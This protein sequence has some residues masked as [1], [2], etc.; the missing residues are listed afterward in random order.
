MKALKEFPVIETERL[1]LSQLQEGDIPFVTE[2]LQDKIFSDLTSN[3][4]Y[5]YTREHA[6]FWMKMSRESF[7]NNTGY[8]FA[9]RNKEGN[10]L[11]AIG[12]HDREDDKAELGY[13]MGK[14][15]WN[16]GYITEAATALIGFG[17]QELQLN[18]IYATYFLQNPASGRIME[19][20]GMEQ[21]ALLKQ[22]VRKGEEYFDIMMYSVLKNKN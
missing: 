6:E 1:I 12:L 19:K 3:I 11:G 22:H 10:I 4:P 13:W 21:E 14:P 2:Y 20:V 7:E 18:K 8:T 9:V 17:F 5:P 16:K 15:F